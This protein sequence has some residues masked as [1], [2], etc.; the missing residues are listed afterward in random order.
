MTDRTR[1]KEA[2]KAIK[3]AIRKL[4]TEGKF[5]RGDLVAWLYHT[6]IG[7]TLFLDMNDRA[8]PKKVQGFG[9]MASALTGIFNTLCEAGD[10]PKGT[11]TG[12]FS[13]RAYRGNTHLAVNLG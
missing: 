11:L 13:H 5:P 1:A 12:A 7:A 2:V 3:R 6:D 10:L 4:R 8:T 9:G